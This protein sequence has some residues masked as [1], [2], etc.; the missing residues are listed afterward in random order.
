MRHQLPAE[1]YLLHDR[2]LR[3]RDCGRA[4]WKGGHFRRMQQL[5]E[6]ATENIRN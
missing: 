2:F 6:A 1:V 5:I 4:Y 3:C